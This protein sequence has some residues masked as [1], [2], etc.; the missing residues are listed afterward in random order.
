MKVEAELLELKLK[1]PFGIAHG[2]SYSRQSVVFHLD[3]GLGE[4]ALA[5]YYGVTPE[6]AISYMQSEAV[7]EVLSGDLSAPEHVLAALP[8]GPRPAMAAVDMAVHDLFGRA[9]GMPL[10]RL[11]GLDPD[12][13][14]MS[15]LTIGLDD[16]DTIRR[17]VEE[18]EGWPI[19]KV[20]LGSG[21]PEADVRT[22]RLVREL[23]DGGICVDANSAWP[24][25]VAADVIP[26]L[27][28]YDLMFV[29]QPIPWKGNVDG[30]HRLREALPPDMPPLIADESVHVAA[31]I[32]PLAG[33]VDG[34]NIKLA[35][36]G[37]LREARRMIEVARTLGMSVMLGC[38]VESSV[39]ITAAAH[40]APMVDY[41]DLDGNLLVTNDPYRGARVEK[42]RLYMPD[43]P[44]L[45]VR[46][47]GDEG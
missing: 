35:K 37:G 25:D 43:G 7:L 36:C 34:I 9:L 22:V 26:R 3:D 18:A 31:D 8:D 27:A 14:P 6:A 16:E 13:A 1:A 10:Y 33:A 4:A 2:V 40:L 39:G 29:E 38:M 47:A 42:G 19:L 28:E 23:F 45:G 30:W 12:R 24:V 15:S 20:K 21:D 17:K 5:P 44:G 32:P 11:W 46:P 41:L